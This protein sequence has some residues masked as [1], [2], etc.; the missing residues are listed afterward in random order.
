M[1]AMITLKDTVRVPPKEFGGKLDNAVLKILREDYEGLVDESIGVIISIIEV[2]KTGDGKVIPGDGAAY[3]ETE[4]NALVYKPEIQE[5]VE[6]TI[7][8]ITEFGAFLRTGPIEGLIHVSQVMNDYIN[9][10]A[11]APAF[12]GK[13]TG[14]KLVV[15]DEV[16][17][18]I[19]TVSLKGSIPNSKIG[20]TMRQL[21]LGKEE[22]L[23]A[24]LK[25]KDKKEREEKRRKKEEKKP[26]AKKSEKK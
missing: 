19:A 7:T 10:D 5:V 3:Y 23:A 12:I 9:Y 26:A 6:G 11:K 21:G 1:Y 13:E 22:W 14:K 25:R 8:E 16:T 24:D 18:R 17:A 15:E 4:F 2:L 20:L